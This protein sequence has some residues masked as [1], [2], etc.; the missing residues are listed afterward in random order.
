MLRRLGIAI[1]AVVSATAAGTG[2]IEN[3]GQVRDRFGQLRPDILFVAELP[4]MELFVHTRG[5][6]YVFTVV[7]LPEELPPEHRWRRLSARR[8]RLD[9]EWLSAE[10]FFRVRASGAH[11]MLRHYYLPGR[12]ALNVAAYQEVQLEELYP[13]VTLRLRLGS[14]GLKYD[15]LCR[16]AE[17]LARVRFRYVGAQQLSLQPDGS[18]LV[19]TPLGTV[20]ELPPVAFQLNRT[21]AAA[22]QLHGDTVSFRAAEA[23]PHLPLVFD[24]GVAWSTFYGGSR[25]EDFTA[26]AADAAGNIYLAGWSVSTDFP[27]VN[28][29]QPNL[30]D[31]LATDIVVVKLSAAGSPIWATYYG[32]DSSDA[33]Y[34]IACDGSGEVVVVGTTT[35][36]NFPVQNAFQST[37]SGYSDAVIVRFNSSGQRLWATYYGGS[38]EETAYGVAFHR[39][40]IFVGGTTSSTNFPVLNALQSVHGGG[41]TDGFVLKFSAA[42]QRLWA[43]YYG[44]SGEEDLRGIAADSLG[45]VLAVG[46]TTSTNFPV[47]NALQPTYGGGLSDAFV[48]KLSGSGQRLWATYYGGN[49]LDFGYGV[50]TDVRNM[51]YICGSSL[52]DSIPMRYAFQSR[53]VAAL[54]AFIAALDT[55]GGLLWGTF[56]GGNGVDEARGI[57]TTPQRRI[58]VVGSTNSSNFPLNQPLQ[59][60][61]AGNGD[62]FVAAFNYVGVQL[63]S[64]Y[65]G[66]SS[67]DIFYRV[68]ADSA[69]N[70]TAAGNSTS[71]DFPLQ[72]AF[73]STLRGGMD[74]V[75]V[76]FEWE[77]IRCWLLRPGPL[78]PGDTISIGFEARGYFF[79]DNVFTAVLSDSTGSFNTSTLIGSLAGQSSGVILGRIPDTVSPS[80][81]YRIRVLGSRPATIGSPSDSFT[82]LPR[83]TPPV[84]TVEPDTVLCPGDS[85]I[86][87]IEPQEMAT[88]RWLLNGNP[89]GSD[90]PQLV[91]RQAGRYSVLVRTPCGEVRS[92]R[93]IVLTSA[94]RPAIPRIE[95]LGARRFCR[96]DSA[97]LRTAN[98]GGE[99]SYEWLRNGVLIGQ[100]APVLTVSQSGSYT[101]V[102]ANL[103]GRVASPDTVHILV[104]EPLAPPELVAE[105]ATRFCQGDSVVLRTRA[106]SAIME[107]RWYRDGT[108]FLRNER[109]WRIAVRQSGW[110]SVEIVN[111]CGAVRSDSLRI[112][113]IPRPLPPRIT[114]EGGTVL[115]AGDS[116]RLRTAEQPGA[117][118][119][120][121]RDGRAVGPNAP[122]Y[123]VRESGTYT[124]EVRT[125]CGAVR[126]P[127]SVVI[128][129][130]DAPPTPPLYASGAP[131]LCEGD[132]L[133]LWTEPFTG[134]QYQW[135][136]NGAPVGADTNVLVVRQAGV[137]RVR[138]LTPCGEAVSDSLVVEVLSPPPAPVVQPLGPLRLCEGD[139]LQLVL[140]ER[141]SG[142]RYTWYR[143]SLPLPYTGDTLT[144]STAATYWVQASNECG[145]AASE[146]LTVVV[147][148]RPPK[149][150]ITQRGDTL[151]S[152]SPVG[153]Q[154]LDSTGAPIPGATEQYFVPPGSG[155]YRVRVTIDGCASESDPYDYVA[156]VQ[157]VAAG[158]RLPQGRRYAPGERIE[159]ELLLLPAG[160]ALPPGRLSARLRY[161]ARV[162]EP[163]APT[164]L[165]SLQQGWRTLPVELQIPALPAGTAQL[166]LAT[167]LLFRVLLGDRDY[168]PLLL[169]SLQFHA[170]RTFPFVALPPDTLWVEICREGGERLFDPETPALQLRILPNPAASAPTLHYAIPEPGDIRIRMWSLYGTEVARLVEGFHQPGHYELLLD[171][172]RLPAGV[173]VV[174]LQ[175]P[176]QEVRTLLYYVP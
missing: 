90:S 42:G 159:L 112:E 119:Q 79:P 20:R 49:R 158:L 127:D 16:R 147:L 55:V 46:M 53:R 174:A 47:Q 32:G 109:A 91:A 18:L 61:H 7:E 141:L 129:V 76:R 125:E 5:I 135:T 105:G 86:L 80:K 151:V 96:G 153:N 145:E 173:Y 101:V 170:E 102:V 54:E 98:Q 108:L 8:Y 114:V 71:S 62:A 143:D 25:L 65:Y 137:Y 67:A 118:Y 12:T 172:E 35:S 43:T 107:Y 115:C 45:A 171:T 11:P 44:G 85:A 83:P 36:P 50:A 24:P 175:T 121:Y 60:S 3:Q 72:N 104:D 27:V 99:T 64:S 131:R 77:S 59:N 48:L 9:L 81:R 144:V 154:W 149:P 82:I 84:I 6:S 15:L 89:I 146:R 122:V 161:W 66:G 123:V 155:R 57:A 31:T 138:L 100:N 70:F 164:P 117:T 113:V 167:G 19:H 23:L 73:Q 157:P 10:P 169:D 130:L 156:R 74:G 94:N 120:W 106:D 56:Y 88:Y 68:A 152:S 41:T 142:I 111:T 134:A 148:P 21:L 132:S 150:E 124:V 39:S 160:Q 168:T 136:R 166:R 29:F 2:F 34:G 40:G 58:L 33:A 116:T 52:S 139:S 103:C 87:R 93:D 163:L 69:G 75:A 26:V 37:L 128:R 126:S 162:L 97:I 14:E 1:A 110:Y 30:R 78:C 133:E 176:T 4:G 95:V 13:G 38:G 165:G 92:Q 63:W 140:R 51:V 17:D 28:A 22:Y